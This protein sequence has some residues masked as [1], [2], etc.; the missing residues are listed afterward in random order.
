MN[1]FGRAPRVRLAASAVVTFALAALASCSLDLDEALV[2]RDKDGGQPFDSGNPNGPPNDGGV[3]TGIPVGPDATACTNDAP[4]TTTHA[5][6]KGKC[7][8]SRKSCTYDLCKTGACTTGACDQS[9][10]VCAAGT[11]YKFKAS[12]FNLGQQI[13]CARCAVAVH[14]FLFVLTPT[15]AVAINMANPLASPPPQIPI[16]GLGFI[17]G[18]MVVSGSRVWFLAGAAGPGPSK[19]VFAYID[20][21]AD[22]FVTKIQATTI[23]ANY[24]RAGSEALTLFPRGGDSAMI[25]GPIEQQLPTTTLE[26]PLAEPLSLTATPLQFP[27]G[28]APRATSGKRLLLGGVNNQLATVAFVDNAGS[29]APATGPATALNEAGAVSVSAT[30]AQ[31]PEGA[32]LWVTG[33]H[34]GNAP[35]PITTRAVKAY[36]L[37]A[38]EAAA[39]D[40]AAGVDVEVFNNPPVIPGANGGVVGPAA[41]L[42]AKTA[43]VTTMARENGTQTAVQFVQ[44]EPLGVIKDGNN[45]RRQVLPIPVG[46]VAAAAGSNGVGYLVANDVPGPPATATVYVFDPACG[47]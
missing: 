19:L 43:I 38:N 12:Q 41:M 21:P 46:A 11:P 15:G 23:L 44:R 40:S 45:P 10:P 14:P 17:P 6:L 9:K 39:V 28:V 35:D 26:A 7:D 36:F 25:V 1:L 31:S 8:L 16:V 34:Q 33:V 3:D 22:P 27:A 30:F 37:V 29:A 13:S 5:C 2:D 47:L 32:V 4:C 42:D 24:N 18:Q 20:V